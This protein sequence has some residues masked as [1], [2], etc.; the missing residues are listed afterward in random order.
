MDRVAVSTNELNTLRTCRHKHWL[1]Y[2]EG[3]IPNEQAHYLDFGKATHSGIEHVY[4]VVMRLQQE[5]K[6]D[7]YPS[8][9]VLQEAGK[10]GVLQWF[11]TNDGFASDSARSEIETAENAMEVVRRFV[12]TM[13]ADDASNRMRVLSVE[14]RFNVQLRDRNGTDRSRLDYFGF[15]D[16][17][18]LDPHTN[19]IIVDEH[20]T[21][22]GPTDAFEQRFEVDPQMP[23]YVYAAREMHGDRVKGLVR[24]NVIRKTGPKKPKVN[25]DGSVSVAKPDTDWATYDAALAEQKD[26]GIPVTEKQLEVL[27]SLS[28]NGAKWLRRLEYRY[29]DREIDRWREEAWDDARM[30]RSM[31]RG[32]LSHSRNGSAC[33]PAYTLSCSYRDVCVQDTKEI[34]A[35][36]YQIRTNRTER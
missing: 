35:A 8:M 16:L 18:L 9:S 32:K 22:A 25:K 23:G 5:A 13:V 15:M 29:S 33:A 26:R 34:R 7:D 6:T 3:L 12:E 36:L 24:M 2:N 27:N 10:S 28:R 20:K 4:K 21:T 17:L 31:R 14:R 19:E 11:K 1:R 30:V